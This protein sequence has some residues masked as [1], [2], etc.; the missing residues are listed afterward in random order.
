MKK[1]N[2]IDTDLQENQDEFHDISGIYETLTHK[3]TKINVEICSSFF[4]NISLLSCGFCN[5]RADL[6]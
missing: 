2:D 5:P 1:L 3:Y 6:K 4:R